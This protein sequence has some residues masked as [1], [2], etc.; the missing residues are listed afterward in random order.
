MHTARLSLFAAATLL[1]ACSEATGPNSSS[2]LDPLG[3]TTAASRRSG[4]GDSDRDADSRLDGGVFTQTND[5]AG[6]AVVAYARRADGSLSYLGTYSTGGRGSA[7]EAGLGSQGAVLLTRNNRV[8]LATNAG[9]DEISS[10]ALGKNGLTLVSTI[11][12]GGTRPISVAATSHVA[13]VLNNGSS[14]VAGFRIGRGGALTPVGGWTRSLSRS[15]ANA[16]QVQ[17][18]K[19]G[20]FLVVV[21]RAAPGFDV[22]PVNH[23]GSLGAPVFS[24]SAGTAPFGFDITARGHVIVSEPGPNTPGTEQSA[25]SYDLQADGSLR[26]ISSGI[27]SLQAA[28]CWVVITKDGR[29]AYTANAG[30]GSISGYAVDSHGALRLITA[31]GRT[32]VTGAGSTPLDMDVSRDS[33][34]LYVI[35]NG[36]GNVMGFSIGRDGSLASVAEVAPPL[37]VRGRG[38]L[39]AF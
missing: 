17:F 32:G 37:P 19:D 11:S 7:P 4:D 26:A 27:P 25:S 31:D 14:S 30:S 36:T 13:Y 15:G 9:S 18:T 20:R 34:Y 35:E 5:A 24:P 8:L 33:R 16:A 28:P 23:D 38:G 21:H 10:F 39:A 29:F 6:N 22:F 1:A 2:M 12:S 3:T